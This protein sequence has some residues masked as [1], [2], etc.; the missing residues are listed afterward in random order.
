MEETFVTPA[1]QQLMLNIEQT[2]DV[3]HVEIVP[4]S[5]QQIAA[6][7]R[8]EINLE[9]FSN[10]IF[11]HRKSADLDQVREKEWRIQLPNGTE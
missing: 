11:P 4:L 5:D 9:K 7:I 3:A 2:K 10:F 1:K 8:P 6:I